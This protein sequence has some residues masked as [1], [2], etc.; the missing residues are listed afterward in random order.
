MTAATPNPGRVLFERV[1]RMVAWLALAT[2]LYV[3]M[4]PSG[5]RNGGDAVRRWSTADLVDSAATALT[6]ALV[7]DIVAAAGD[8]QPRRMT[9]ELPALPGARAR[10]LLGAAAGADIAVRGIDRT[11]ASGLALSATAVAWPSG[12]VDVRLAGARVGADAGADAWPLLLRDAGGTLDSIANT[13]RMGWRLAS[14]SAPLRASVGASEARVP[15]RMPAFT[16]RVMLMAQP[17]WDAKFVAAALEEAGWHV[18]GSLRVSPRAAVTLGAPARLDLARYAVVVVLDSMLVDAAAITRFVQQGG[19]L[20]L[21]GDALRLPALAAISPVRV[22][23]VRGAVAGALLTETPARGLEA[24]ELVVTPGA[25]VVRSDTSA[26]G[27]AEPVLVAQRVGA[28]RVVASAYRNSWHWRM[29][30][31]DDGAAQHR[32]WWSGVLALAAG[33][34]AA[35]GDPQADAYPGD[36]APYADLVARLGG[37][38]PTDRAA[39]PAQVLA[40]SALDAVLDRLRAAPGLLFMVIAVALLGEWAS[41][42][43]RGHR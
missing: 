19:G 8:T 18:D 24:W 23:S 27:P 37:P 43:L 20:V 9:V 4:A 7:R 30:G 1:L 29:E 36:A 5:V 25:S 32:R 6:D 34:P 22:T 31:T 40:R 17:G 26:P 2:A 39:R 10:A 21:G 14:A 41:R 16:R 35:G 15:V 42:R 28:G 33:V 38:V 13:S 3:V 11:R 12:A